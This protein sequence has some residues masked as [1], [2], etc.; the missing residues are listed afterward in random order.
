MGG[1]RG[2]ERSWTQKEIGFKYGF[3][4]A[5]KGLVGSEGIK[6]CRGLQ[7]SAPGCLVDCGVWGRKP[8]CSHVSGTTGCVL[9]V[10]RGLVG[11]GVD[12]AVMQQSIGV[13][14]W[15]GSDFLVVSSG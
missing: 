7:Q 1:R 9:G 4:I 6:L 5:Q 13:L 8:S 12:L 3:G 2:I 11:S 14:C 10:V 15:S